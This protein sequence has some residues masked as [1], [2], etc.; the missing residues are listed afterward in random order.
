[1]TKP[2]TPRKARRKHGTA[3]A[4]RFHA[5]MGAAREKKISATTLRM[6]T[7][8]RADCIFMAYEADQR[9]AA[10]IIRAILEDVL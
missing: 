4:D 10:R 2:R 6:V 3:D 9:T 7:A 5:T 8:L 1:M